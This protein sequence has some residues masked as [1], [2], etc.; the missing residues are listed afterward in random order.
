MPSPP[1]DVETSD[2]PKQE[3]R[4]DPEFQARLLEQ[5]EEEQQEAIRRA[6]VLNWFVVPLTVVALI[7]GIVLAFSDDHIVAL[8]ANLVATAI[9][10]V[11]Y[12]VNRSRVRAFLGLE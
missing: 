4:L 7:V 5:M 6:T 8:I 11:L 12:R 9:A 2:A 10:Y 3:V 1:D